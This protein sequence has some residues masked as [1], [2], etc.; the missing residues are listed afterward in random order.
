MQEINRSK[1]YYFY[2]IF[3]AIFSVF[4]IYFF[5]QFIYVSSLFSTLSEDERV[6]NLIQSPF[7]KIALVLLLI[8]LPIFLFFWAK[9]TNNFNRVEKVSITILRYILAY[10]MFFYG[11]EKIFFKQFDITYNS[12]DTTLVNLDSFR[13][14]WFYFGRSTAFIILM[15]LMELIPAILLL[16]RRTYLAGSIILLPVIFNVLLTNIFNSISPVTLILSILFS[17]F[18]IQISWSKKMIL[19]E[20]LRKITQKSTVKTNRQLII[21]KSI[22]IIWMLIP[23]SL[24]LSKKLN[25]SDWKVQYTA[26][27]GAYINTSDSVK[28]LPDKIYIEQQSRWNK[29]R[30]KSKEEIRI[31]LMLPTKDSLKLIPYYYGEKKNTF[32]SANM[33]IAQYELKDSTLHLKGTYQNKSFSTKYKRM[34][35]QVPRWWLD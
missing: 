10:F 27:Q 25:P 12:L 14:T 28:N 23:L 3:L 5:F 35:L 2:T 22:F 6:R 13:A 7:F 17:L 30:L 9:K 33:I 31:K 20:F 21:L 24:K 32:D 11:T 16:F 8:G 1:S 15:G 34:N 19:I 4:P 26:L 18:S 29:I